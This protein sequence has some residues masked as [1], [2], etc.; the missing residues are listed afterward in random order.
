[1]QPGLLRPDQFLAE[2]SGR[3][4]RDRRRK[5]EGGEAA[6]TLARSGRA[7]QREAL[8][9]LNGE[10]HIVDDPAPRDRHPET[11]DR[12][13]RHAANRSRSLSPAMVRQTMMAT[14]MPPGRSSAC[15]AMSISSAPSLTRIP[16]EV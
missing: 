7:D 16:S 3:S 8:A 10:A 9:G 13:D 12:P 6:L 14:R 1:S 5:A 4:G 11:V 15:G 2:E